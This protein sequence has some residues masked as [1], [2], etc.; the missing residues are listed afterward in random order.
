MAKKSELGAVKG[1]VGKEP[2]KAKR[3]QGRPSAYSLE[4]AERICDRIAV[5]ES[6]RSICEDESMPDKATVFRWLYKH[7]EFA[8]IYA[9][10]KQASGFVDEDD[11]AEIADDARNDYM[12]K[13]DKD[14]NSLGYFLNGEHVQRSKLRW[15]HRRWLLERKQPKRYGAKV[16]VNHGGQADNPLTVLME[17]VVGT[18][19]PVKK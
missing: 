17:Q 11:M 5:G 9:R 15:E 12:E 3:P 13:F 10:A 16:D 4:I 8:T 6:V 7:E 19:F 18:K 14:G 2:T 1:K